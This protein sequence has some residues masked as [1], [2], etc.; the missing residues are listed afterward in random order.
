LQ[1][2]IGRIGVCTGVETILNGEF[3]YYRDES[4][5]VKRLIRMI[6]G[7]QSSN[8]D[9]AIP[10]DCNASQLSISSTTMAAMALR[11]RRMGSI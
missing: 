8:R 11:K 7:L 1:Q 3:R 4:V 5:S 9:C 6:F 10:R 2:D